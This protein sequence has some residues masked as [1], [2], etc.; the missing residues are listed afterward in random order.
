[1][2]P[3]HGGIVGRGHGEGEAMV[4]ETNL[5]GGDVRRASGC[6]HTVS[7]KTVVT[8]AATSTA[9]HVYSQAAVTI[10]PQGY[11]HHFHQCRVRGPQTPAK[12]PLVVMMSG[13]R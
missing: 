10:G 7:A 4:R 8:Q 3:S 6:T 1:M 9:R 2:F 11:T 13:G 5:P 12:G